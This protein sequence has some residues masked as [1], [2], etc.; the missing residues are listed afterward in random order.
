[1]KISIII[2]TFNRPLLL[3][4]A[5]ASI[6]LQSYKNWEVIIFDDSNGGK[7]ILNII[8]NFRELTPNNTTLYLNSNSP[9]YFFKK[10]WEISPQIVQGEV[11]VR[12][13]DDDLL[14]EN[15]L[16]LISKIYTEHPLLDYS[17]GSCIVFEEDKLINKMITQTPL[18]A[19]KTRDIWAGYLESHP[20][21][22][23][24]S[25]V[26]NYYDKPRHYTSII[27]CSKA[28]IMCSYHT[29]VIRTSS[30]LSVLNKF[31]IVSNHVDDLEAMGS[32]DYLGLRHTS[33][34]STLSYVRKHDS[35]RVTDDNQL[36][37]NELLKVRDKVEYLRHENFTSNVYLENI[38]DNNQIEEI[39]NSDRSN[40]KQY[41]NKVKLKANQL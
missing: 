6:S 26:T 14:S 41:F 2:R 36:I 10:S 20:W 18:E 31:N 30:A 39:S 12:L 24:W 1:M 16:K 35:G 15:S 8:Q 9:R 7:D 17:Y 27:H 25:W 22:E 32:L 29:Y 5:L 28:S 23:P 21:R 13:D 19:P 4:Q 37:I 3:K 40:F 33:L 34:K 38:K 11:M